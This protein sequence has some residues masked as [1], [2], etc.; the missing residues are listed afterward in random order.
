LFARRHAPEARFQRIVRLNGMIDQP[1]RRLGPDAIEHCLH[2]LS[3]PFAGW[4]V[5]DQSS[6]GQ[7]R[8]A[9]D[10]PLDQGNKRGFLAGK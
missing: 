10:G 7:L 6:F 8:H 9:L 2:E 5:A 4:L 1:T 3:E